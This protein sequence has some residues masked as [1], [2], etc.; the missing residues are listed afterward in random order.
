[1]RVSRESLLRIAKETAQ[2][3]AYNDTDIVAGNAMQRRAEQAA[4]Y[5]VEKVAVKTITGTHSVIIIRVGT[6][7]LT[8][9][10]SKSGI[11]T[12]ISRSN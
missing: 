12:P 11:T 3:R 7:K 10:C 9:F 4:H 8:Y 6:D 5:R 1:M 2:E